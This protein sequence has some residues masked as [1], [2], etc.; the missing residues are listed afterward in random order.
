VEISDAD[1]VIFVVELEK[2]R[3]EALGCVVNRAW[4]ER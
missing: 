4:Q 1:L 3:V 2:E